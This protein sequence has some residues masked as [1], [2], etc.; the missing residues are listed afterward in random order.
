[1]L[2]RLEM[3][4]Y[5]NQYISLKCIGFC[6]MAAMNRDKNAYKK[7][8]CKRTT[9]GNAILYF[10]Q[11][12]VTF[13]DGSYWEYYRPR[14]FNMYLFSRKCTWEIIDGNSVK[15]KYNKLNKSNN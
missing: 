9:V 6:P 2:S 15:S 3:V 14:N 11:N 4:V 5:K 10:I 7:I 12:T 8:K 13:R 1:M